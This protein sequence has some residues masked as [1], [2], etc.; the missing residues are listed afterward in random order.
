MKQRESTGLLS[1]L[2]IKTPES[3]ILLVG[4]LLF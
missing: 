1:S 4:P 3:K 2:G